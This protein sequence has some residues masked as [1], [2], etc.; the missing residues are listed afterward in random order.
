MTFDVSTMVV[1]SG[2]SIVGYQ[3]VWFAI[4]SKS[5]ASR[6]GLLP[7][8]VRVDTFRRVFPLERA[9]LVA[10]V[11]IV[12]GIAGLTVAGVRWD[13]SLSS[14]TSGLRLVVPSVTVVILGV[15]TGLS[16]LLLSVLALPSAR[17][18][19]AP[20]VVVDLAEVPAT[21]RPLGEPS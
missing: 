3:S 14:P 19:S 16:S 10:L 2:L 20:T 15:Q 9:L 11:A 8:D 12:V 4:L 13:A 5:F 7:L 17:G 21:A 6:E 1:A 18:R